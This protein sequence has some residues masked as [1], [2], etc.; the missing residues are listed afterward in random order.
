M[1]LG[2]RS[3]TLYFGSDLAAEVR[4]SVGQLSGAGRRVAV[5]T[6]ANI[7][8]Q[9]AASLNAMLGT[10]PLLAMEPGEVAKSLSGLARI[11]DFFSANQIDR[12]GA[13]FAV[14]GGV[15][16][17]LGGFAAATWLRGIEF[18]QVPTTLLAMVDSSVGGKTGINIAA[19]KNLV[20]AFHQPRGV[21]ISTGLLTTLP[22]REF[23]A[24][25]GGSDQVRVTGRAKIVR[26]ARSERLTPSAARLLT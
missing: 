8:G 4:R 19:G 15:V 18:Y 22:P 6:D 2:E 25:N 13:V 17:D 16:G 1:N 20:G 23:A 11:F 12:D 10:V 26:A 5:I 3:Y 21:F 14:G 24:G 9:Q 7:A